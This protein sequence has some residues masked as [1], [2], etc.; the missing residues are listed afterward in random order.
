MAE[1]AIEREFLDGALAEA[2]IIAQSEGLAFAAWTPAHEAALAELVGVSENRQEWISSVEISELIQRQVEI[3]SMAA[4]GLELLGQAGAEQGISSLL[5]GGQ[6][7]RGKGFWFNINAELVVYG[8][9]EPDAAVTLGGRPIRL[10]P[11]GTFSYRFAFPDGQYQLP[12][13]ATS[14]ENEVRRAELRFSRSTEYQ[15]EVGAHPQDKSLEP[16]TTTK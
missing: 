5:G 1:F 2:P 6:A 11:D 8:A 4:V 10:R 3:S 15:G 12:A 14:A 13:A 7:A 9:T 16:M